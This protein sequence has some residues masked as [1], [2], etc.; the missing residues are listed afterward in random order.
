MNSDQVIVLSNGGY[1][2]PSEGNRYAKWYVAQK[3]S[4]SVTGPDGAPLREELTITPT[5]KTKIKEW[6][7]LNDVGGVI[8]S[9]MTTDD[10]G[11]L[12]DASGNHVMK[13]GGVYDNRTYEFNFDSAGEYHIILWIESATSRDHTVSFTI[14]IKE[15]EPKKKISPQTVWGTILIVISS[16]LLLGVIVYFV[17]TGRRTKFAGATKSVRGSKGVAPKDPPAQV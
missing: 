5:D 16:G 14:V 8:P 13:E 2:T 1:M 10:L 4:F 6:K 12:K 7:H 11:Y 17:Q 15:D 3:L 9:G